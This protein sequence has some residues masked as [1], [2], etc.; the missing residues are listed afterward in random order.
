MIKE[1]IKKKICNYRWKKMNTHNSTSLEHSCDINKIEIG[2]MTYGIINVEEFGN[3]NESLKIG[4]YC[5]IANKVVFI[6]GGEHSYKNVTTYPIKKKLNLKDTEAISKGKITVEDDVWIGYGST[7]LSGVTIG[8][9]AIIGAGTVVSKD[10]PPYAIYAGNR[11][12]RYRFSPEVIKKLEKIDF[13]SIKKEKILRN[14]D[15]FYT[16]LN[17]DNVEKIVNNIINN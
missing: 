14:I 10:I 11:I 12:I 17:N 1:L 4:S 9:G 8:K 15:L 6:L 16:D 13:S 5:S 7:I 2:N 3:P